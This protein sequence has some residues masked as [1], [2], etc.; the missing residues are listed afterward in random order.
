MTT[1][2][3]LRLRRKAVLKLAGETFGVAEESMRLQRKAQSKALAAKDA[4]GMPRGGALGFST[5]EDIALIVAL[6]AVI[7]ARNVLNVAISNG[8]SPCRPRLFV[9]PPAVGCSTSSC[10]YA[11]VNA[12]EF[13]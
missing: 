6:D 4:A 12:A 8:M 10:S 7:E 3:E 1:F 9:S 2:R 5:P 13:C 11:A